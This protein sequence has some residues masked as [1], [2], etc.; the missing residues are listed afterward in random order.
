MQSWYRRVL[1][2][3]L[4]GDEEALAGRLSKLP[5]SLCVSPHAWPARQKRRQ[6]WSGVA[7]VWRNLR[8]RAAAELLPLWLVPRSYV[9]ATALG[10]A[11]CGLFEKAG[12]SFAWISNRLWTAWLAVGAFAKKI[13]SAAEKR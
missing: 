9:C 2:R 12:G 4:V 6:T 7:A 3:S 1:Q 13:V 5:S 8:G 11:A 10:E